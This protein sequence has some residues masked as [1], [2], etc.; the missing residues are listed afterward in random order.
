[1]ILHWA[2]SQAVSMVETIGAKVDNSVIEEFGRIPDPHTLGLHVQV[3]PQLILLL[4]SMWVRGLIVLMITYLIPLH[5]WM[6]KMAGSVRV[7]SANCRELRELPKEGIQWG[8]LST[9][10]RSGGS[11]GFAADWT[12]LIEGKNYLETVFLKVK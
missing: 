1:M 7:V 5:T 9:P 6:P 4:L 3:L 8:E 11:T 2:A 12:P 10:N